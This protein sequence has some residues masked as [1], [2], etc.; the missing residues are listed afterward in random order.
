M[1]LTND[2]PVLSWERTPHVDRTVTFKQEL[3]SG[4]VGL[5]TK[6]DWLT[7][8]QSQCDF[9][10]ERW[11]KTK[12]I[13][14]LPPNSVLIVDNVA[15]HNVQLNLATS[16]SS[17]KIVRLTRFQI[18]ALYSL[19]E[20]RNPWLKTFKTDGVLAE[21]GY[22][23]LRLPPYHPDLNPTQL[24][25]G[26]VKEHVDRNNVSFRADDAIKVA[27]EKFS[28]VTKKERSSRCKNTCQCEHSCLRLEPML[29]DIS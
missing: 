6:T 19:I 12:S 7:D 13:P 22:S 17:R 2:R 28:V 14:K 3:I 23:V 10:Y 11:L 4:Q 9:D 8:R 16:S 20:L 26:L 29:G 24:I 5:D 21:H 27:E 15:Y 1:T 18:V 25:Q